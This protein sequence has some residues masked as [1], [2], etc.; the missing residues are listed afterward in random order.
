[1]RRKFSIDSQ[2]L[3]EFNELI[4]DTLAYFCDEYMISGELSYV[5]IMALAEARLAEMNQYETTDT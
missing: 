3:D 2:Q 5:L 1:M 4:E